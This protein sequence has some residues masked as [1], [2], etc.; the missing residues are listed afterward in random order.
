MSL[1]KPFLVLLFLSVSALSAHGQTA[2]SV[3]SMF[4]VGDMWEPAQA[5]SMGMAGVG[6]SNPQY[7]YLNNINPALLVFNK[8]TTFHAGLIGERRVAR[9]GSTAERN[10]DGN[11]SYLMLGL[12]LKAHR[13]NSFPAI[14]SSAV[15]LSPYSTVNYGFSYSEPVEG[16]PGVANFTQ[17]GSGGINQ[18]SWSNGFSLGRYVSV[19][20]RTNYLFSSIETNFGKSVQLS[21]DQLVLITTN[22]KKRYT[23]SDFTFAGGVSLHLDSLGSKQYRF[24]LGA[25]YTR[26]AD[27]RTNYFETLEKFSQS[28]VGP[29][30]DTIVSTQLGYTYIPGSIGVGLSFG[31]AETWALAF[32]ARTTDFT[33]FTAF[34]KSPT[35]VG[36][37]WKLAAGFDLTPD[38]TSMGSYLMR[39]TYRTGV[40]LEESPFLANNN[41]L[42]DFGINFGFSAPVS[43]VS[44]ID[45]AFRWG[46]RG[47]IEQNTIEEDYFKI[48][49]GVTFNDKW[50]IKRR[51]D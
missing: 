32:D 28:G 35:P 30:A 51:F 39:M 14:W 11:M 3:Y 13:F 12:P 24:N 41:P 22:T 10:Y 20:L 42:R 46:R 4:G 49:F 6:I 25:V 19:G 26:D 47:N 40:S 23:Y 18:L 2:K 29:P 21:E 37:G 34:E 5:N 27:V 33:K 8:L 16:S 38:P 36:K 43:R 15:S 9:D 48:Y 45:V 31:K 17:R 50:F 7:W 44:S 1:N